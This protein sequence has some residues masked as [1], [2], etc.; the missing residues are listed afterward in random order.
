[1]NLTGREK[2]G[3]LIVLITAVSILLV[4]E[5]ASTSLLNSNSETEHNVSQRADDVFVLSKQPMYLPKPDSTKNSFL[6]IGNSHTYS[7]PGLERGYPLRPDPGATLVDKLAENIKEQNP[8]LVG[9]V[10]YYRLSY[11]N[12]LPYEMLMRIGHLIYHQQT[13]KIVVI[14]LT[15]RNIA[16]DRELRSE[17]FQVYEDKPYISSLK[18]I[19]VE[20]SKDTFREIL[21]TIE[22]EERT[23]LFE[24]EKERTRSYADRLDEKITDRAEKKITLLGS[25]ADLRARIFREFNYKVI[26]KLTR[27]ADS[28]P[29]YDVIERDLEF[30]LNCLRLLTNLLHSR[31]AK[32]VFYYAPERT[33][34][35]SLI[36]KTQQEKVMGE[37]KKFA[38]SQDAIVLDA[39]NVVPNE[40]WG[41]D[42]DTP[43]RSHFTETG[44]KLL[45]DFIVKETAKKNVWEALLAP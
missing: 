42:Y 17:V 8:Q 27:N 15:W 4:S 3:L 40:Y 41:W 44:H 9:R 1:M 16:R 13:P 5:V 29:Q 28:T 31:G 37:F 20:T 39:R 10:N 26:G 19:L 43:D 25:S 36:D 22:S 38:E 7:L 32:M 2:N 21:E 12:F 23:A 45:A 18:Q 30:N 24:E 35:Q 14:G 6:L 34:L 11:P 33:D